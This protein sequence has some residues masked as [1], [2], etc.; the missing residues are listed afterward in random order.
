MNYKHT[1]VAYL[2]IIAFLVV[3]LL[4]AWL[5]ITGAQDGWLG[6]LMA[7]ILAIF[8]W[9]FS[10][11]TVVID[12]GQ[13]ILSFGPGLVKKNIEL[14]EVA[15]CQTVRNKWWYGWG[16]HLTPKGWLYN[17]SGLLAVEILFKNGKTLRVGT[18]QPEILSAAIKA[19]LR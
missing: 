2:L 12:A 16:I 19:N 4:S 18:D 3:I 5:A 15:A 8:A 6:G 17:V 14:S 10:S 9:L 1:Q 7:L 13:L 11:L